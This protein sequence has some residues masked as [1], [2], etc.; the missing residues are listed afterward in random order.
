[1]YE[2][3]CRKYYKTEQRSSI[4]LDTFTIIYGRRTQVCITTG[5]RRRYGFHSKRGISNS[6]VSR[7][8]YGQLTRNLGKNIDLFSSMK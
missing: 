6:L 2:R 8:I 3:V 1:M 5:F 4:S 7:H